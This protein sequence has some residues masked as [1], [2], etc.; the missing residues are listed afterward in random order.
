MK[1]FEDCK[2]EKFDIGFYGGKFIP[3]HKGHDY[4]IRCAASQCKKVFVIIFIGGDDE[5]KIL[6]NLSE[7]DKEKFSAEKRIGRLKEIC[8]NYKNVSVHVIDVTKLK[9]EDGSEDWDAET[10]LVL[11]ITGKMDAVY[12]SEISYDEYFSSAY[13]WATHILVDPPR[14]V[15]PISATKIRNMKDEKERKKWM[16]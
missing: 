9:H 6:E 8:S 11:N 15:F 7:K 4:C 3:F 2:E 13:P 16:M 10:P 1:K 14:E 12:S 5:L